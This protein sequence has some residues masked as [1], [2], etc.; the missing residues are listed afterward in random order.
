M[1]RAGSSLR[2]AA[3][4][5]PLFLFL[6][7]FFL[8]PLWTM[9][10]VSMRDPAV[11]AALPR[12]AA[13]ISSW[14]GEGVPDTDTQG[15]LLADLRETD[16]V[17]LGGAVR[18][19]NSEVSGFRTLI[20]KTQRAAKDGAPGAPADL[21]ALDKRWADPAFWTAIRNASS[22]YTDRN[23]L[24]AVDLTR[25]DAG[26]I[27]SLP[28]GSSAN[29]LIIGRT[30]LIAGT[31]T[32]CC[33]LIGLPYAMLMAAVTGWKR[34]LL[35]M[36]VLLPLWTSLLVRTAA[37]FILLQDQG[38]INGALQALGLASGP[39]PL[40]FNRTGV[41]VAMTHV[42][43]PFMVLPIYSVLNTIPKTLMP[44]A[45]SMGA[46]PLKAFRRILLPLAMPGILSG[47]L[48]V[49]MVAIG[50]YITPALVGGPNDQMI[51][52]IIAFYA[53]QTANWGMA[54]ALGLILLVVTTVLY[55]V[56]G[57]LSRGSTPVGA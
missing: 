2:S 53:L 18:R 52:S 40:I 49:F 1:T 17:A 26:S 7:L 6:A 48:L 21:A 22:A 28:P 14:S 10:S 35:L 13:A 57:R 9:V 16:A 34:N 25:N 42:L 30:F 29:R 15:A 50:Y 38:V 19:L 4:I 39:L 27:E 5:A 43:L 51:S 46:P 20:P 32:L 36:A 12:T 41:V 55:V 33:L 54:G 23:L 11:A 3:L 8:W 56:Y 47:S 24:A 45:A 37:W 31:I 44:A